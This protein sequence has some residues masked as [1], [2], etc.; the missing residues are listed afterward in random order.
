MASNNIFFKFKKNSIQCS[1]EI[2]KVFLQWHV[3]RWTER[4]WQNR[5]SSYIAMTYDLISD[6]STDIPRTLEFA[7]HSRYALAQPH[8]TPS[9][10]PP[11]DRSRPL[12]S[13]TLPGEWG[14]TQAAWP[15]RACLISVNGRELQSCGGVELDGYSYVWLISTR[16]AFS[17]G[18][19]SLAPHPLTPRPG[20]SCGN[21][22][23]P[24]RTTT[25][26]PCQNWTNEP[27]SGDLTKFYTNSFTV[28][29]NCWMTS[30][31][32]HLNHAPLDIHTVSMNTGKLLRSYTVPLLWRF[33]G[34][35]STLQSIPNATRI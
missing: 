1:Y 9:C 32:L 35:E 13:T 5:R 16:P 8:L 27:S 15:V 24:H 26:Q 25:M 10:R 22:S 23:I 28:C 2:L 19:L 12:R 4:R 29:D 7:G 6:K 21:W 3:T 20:W 31:F 33:F 30:V 34:R 11:S 18:V 17:P 14:A